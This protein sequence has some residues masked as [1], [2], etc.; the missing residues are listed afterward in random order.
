M[1][2]MNK[3]SIQVRAFRYGMPLFLYCI[4]SSRARHST[5]EVQ[6]DKYITTFMTEREISYFFSDSGIAQT[7]ISED[8]LPY[9][10][11]DGNMVYFR[12]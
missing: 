12:R 7:R 11:V 2:S 10:R 3:R 6:N 5:I 8:R 9:E 4:S 1:K